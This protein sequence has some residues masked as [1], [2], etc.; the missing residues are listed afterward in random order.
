MA[1]KGIPKKE[2]PNEQPKSEAVL[3]KSNNENEKMMTF[4][5][6]TPW[7]GLTSN[8]DVKSDMIII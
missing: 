3:I 2:K 7:F 1:R 5:K 4:C 6:R 8:V